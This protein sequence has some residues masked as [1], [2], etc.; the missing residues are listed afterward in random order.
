[1]LIG[2]TRISPSDLDAATHRDALTKEGCQRVFSDEGCGTTIASRPA[3]QAALGTLKAGDVLVVWRLDR[4]GHSLSQL[5]HLIKDLGDRRITLRSVEEGIDTSTPA[6]APLFQVAR[7]LMEF[8]RSL[9]AGRTRAG[10]AAA[11]Q[12]GGR[13]GRKPKLTPEKV[14]QAQRLIDQGESPGEVAK[15]FDISVATLYRHIPA[16]ASNRTTFD[17]FAGGNI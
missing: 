17:L 14:A 15:T 10:Q 3:L 12:R 13:A 2:Y 9:I 6:G 1:M 5:I 8:E 11:R 4:L 16:P 7:W